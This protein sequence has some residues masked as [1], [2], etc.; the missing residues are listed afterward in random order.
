MTPN[1]NKEKFNELSLPFEKAIL[2]CDTHQELLM[3]ACIM[4][5]QSKDIFDAYLGEEG[6]KQMFEGFVNT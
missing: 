5:T 1:V 6:R 4:M 3:L 2:L